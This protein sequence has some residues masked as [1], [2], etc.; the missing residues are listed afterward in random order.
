MTIARRE[1]VDVS[2][3]R[4][5]HCIT[6]CV[7][8]AFLLGE[9][10]LDRKQWLED[11]LDSVDYTG[12]L[13]REG[14]ARI[15]AELAGI[16]D[17]IGSSAE[18]WQVRMEKLKN[19]RSFGRFFAASRDKLRDLAFA[20]ECATSGQPRWMRGPVTRRLKR[21]SSRVGSQI[22]TSPPIRHRHDL[23]IVWY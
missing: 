7:R 22:S 3:T 11:R 20:P 13:F 19:G 1:L 6:R 10:L 5:Y 2:V 16:L 4:W 12:R 15:S 14:K 21:D 8:R 23:P 18:G 17:R 9:G